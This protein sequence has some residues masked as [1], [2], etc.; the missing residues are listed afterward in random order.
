MEEKDGVF[1]IG[2]G[3]TLRSFESRVG[4]AISYTLVRKT[5]KYQCDLVKRKK[6]VVLAG[7][8]DEGMPAEYI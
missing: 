5:K 1:A 6:F 8:R 4:T 3:V 2:G 7:N